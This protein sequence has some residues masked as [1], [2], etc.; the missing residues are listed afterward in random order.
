MTLA[1]IRQKFWPLNGRR[2]IRQVIRKC[3]RCFKTSPKAIQP[4]MGNL[5]EQ[6]IKP[7]RPFSNVGIDFCGPF[8]FENPRDAMPK[9]YRLTWQF[10][11]AL[12]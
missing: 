11:Y 8:K 6:R 2:T 5:P 4:I 3:I 7:A 10:L 9:L 1:S 12:Q